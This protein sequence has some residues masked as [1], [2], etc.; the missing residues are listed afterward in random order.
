MQGPSENEKTPIVV[1]K[2]IREAILD[3]LFK[4]GDWLPESM[5]RVL[6]KLF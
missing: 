5:G 6:N 2:K 1:I 3:E 4:P